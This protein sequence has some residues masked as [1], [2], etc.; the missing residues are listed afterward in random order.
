MKYKI[1]IDF[2]EKYDQSKLKYDEILISHT[3]KLIQTVYSMLQQLILIGLK[4]LN[5]MRKVWKV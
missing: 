3:K 5:C 2:N 4:L 1:I